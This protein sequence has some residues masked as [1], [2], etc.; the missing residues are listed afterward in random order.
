MLIFITLL[1]G[2]PVK[3][4]TMLP[5][6]IYIQTR[7]FRYIWTIEVVK[8]LYRPRLSINSWVSEEFLCNAGVQQG[9]PLSPLLFSLFINDLMA[10]MKVTWTDDVY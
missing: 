9:C 4:S 10:F 6:L 8:K 3:L 2:F 1:C 5:M 7:E